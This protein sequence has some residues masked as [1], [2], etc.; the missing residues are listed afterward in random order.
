[1]AGPILMRVFHVTG[2]MLLQMFFRLQES[3]A[4]L[5]E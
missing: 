4:I 1:M 3:R 2:L 5:L